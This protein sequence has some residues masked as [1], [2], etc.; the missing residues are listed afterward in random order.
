LKDICFAEIPLLSGLDRI[1]L[2]SLI[3]NFEQVNA[4]R[5]PLEKSI[6]KVGS[7]MTLP[8]SPMFFYFFNSKEV[9]SQ[10]YAASQ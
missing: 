8:F 1:N 10:S 9:N 7:K 4:L 3:P 2:A 5:N 6:K